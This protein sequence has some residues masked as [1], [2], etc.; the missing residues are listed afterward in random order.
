MKKS[1]ILM[2]FC[3]FCFTI[4][5]S[6]KYDDPPKTNNKAMAQKIVDG[7]YGAK[8]HCKKE[9]GTSG[10]WYPT[11]MIE[12]V[13]NEQTNSR[14]A[15]KSSGNSETW[16]TEIG[17]TGPKGGLD[18]NRSNSNSSNSSKSSTES[19]VSGYEYECR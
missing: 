17:L 6:A 18:V 11:K 12:T 5:V 9:D 14:G 2:M 16:S 19:R 10:K 1:F 13:G 3:L 15:S 7:L 4:N 8:G